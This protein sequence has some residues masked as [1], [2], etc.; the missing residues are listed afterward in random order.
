MPCETS[1]EHLGLATRLWL[2]THMFSGL[3]YFKSEFE[4]AN[5]SKKKP[6]RSVMRTELEMMSSAIEAG[7][8]T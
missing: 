5:S 4:K 2:I 8:Q 7:K 6:H 1:N 3:L